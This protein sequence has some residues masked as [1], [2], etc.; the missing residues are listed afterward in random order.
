MSTKTS[1][2]TGHKIITALLAVVLILSMVPMSAFAAELPA[3]PEARAV[4]D[5]TITFSNLSGLAVNES[6]E[7]QITDND[8]NPAT[9]GIQRANNVARA[10]TSWKVW[11]AS[12]IINSEFY[13]DVNNNAVSRVYDY[14]I[15]IVGGT[16]DNAI[17]SKTSTYGRLDFKFE[18]WGPIITGNCWLKG[19]VTGS[20]NNI[21]VNWSM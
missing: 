12:G 2:F 8:G 1:S 10:G 7:Y 20:G 3:A 11:Y 17:L 18:S 19:T 5:D 16:Y 21:S 9:I 4:S 15:I 13:M 6:V 14:K